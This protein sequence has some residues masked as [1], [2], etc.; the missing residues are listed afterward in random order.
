MDRIPDWL[1]AGFLPACDVR[2]IGIIND[3]NK[4][5]KFFN[6]KIRFSFQSIID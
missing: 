2:M 4:T 3:V 6:A 5:L 1:H